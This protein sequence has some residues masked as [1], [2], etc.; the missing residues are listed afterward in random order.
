MKNCS[1]ALA[2]EGDF[3]RPPILEINVHR[4]VGPVV[5][6]SVAHDTFCSRSGSTPPELH[7][8]RHQRGIPT[9]EFERLGEIHLSDVGVFDVERTVETGPL[10]APV[11]RVVESH[12]HIHGPA[13]DAGGADAEL[14]HPGGWGNEVVRADVPAVAR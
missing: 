3:E 6:R 5:H 4:A 7:R 2:G 13:G 8:Y 12:Y 9:L 14:M 11:V 10:D 1:T